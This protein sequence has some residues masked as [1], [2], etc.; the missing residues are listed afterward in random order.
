MALSGGAGGWRIV[1]IPWS[2][3]FGEQAPQKR[4][5][6]QPPEFPQ[7]HWRTSIRSERRCLILRCCRRGHRPPSPQCDHR[8]MPGEKDD[9]IV[10]AR[11]VS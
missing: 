4:F 10:V 8:G 6:G 3:D 9:F 5:G 11:G 2:G 1:T 7:P